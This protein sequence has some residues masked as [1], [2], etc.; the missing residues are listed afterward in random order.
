MKTIILS[1]IM[2]IALS[3]GTLVAQPTLTIHEK[4][5]AGYFVNFYVIDTTNVN[6]G[7]TGDGIVWNF[8]NLV[9]TNKTYT[10]QYVVPSATEKGDSFPV[11]TLAEV[12]NDGTTTYLL[13]RNDTTYEIGFW[14]NPTGILLRYNRW[15]VRSVSP[16]TYKTVC[17][18]NARY[19]YNYNSFAYKSGG[20]YTITA[21]SYG[22]LVLP[23]GTY[24]NVVRVRTE[25]M[26]YDTLQG[27]GGYVTQVHRVKNS[28]YNL[29]NNA[30]LFE[31][32]SVGVQSPSFSNI[33]RGVYMHKNPSNSVAESTKETVKAW[34]NQSTLHIAGLQDDVT[35]VYLY[36][37]SGRLVTRATPTYAAATAQYE[38]EQPIT[39]GIY[40]VVLPTKNVQYTT[41]LIVN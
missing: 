18:G 23:Q 11:S 29:H 38:L 2:G 1:A 37:A 13:E 34:L 12:G 20:T 40:Y 41:K 36:D 32:D 10:K 30:P 33:R 26:Y 15:Q 3:L 19:Y 24:N 39:T 4:F 21:D 17:T 28:W 25:T 8:A 7:A 35:S 5:T 31:M 22:T 27:M 16:Q 14:L 6:S 9:K